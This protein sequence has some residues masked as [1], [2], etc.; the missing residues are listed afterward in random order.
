MNKSNDGTFHGG[1]VR[2]RGEGRGVR[3]AKA[4]ASEIPSIDPT[5]AQ[6]RLS[7][8]EDPETSFQAAK[9]LQARKTKL[10]VLG[11]PK[12]ALDAGSQ[13]YGRCVKH[14]RSYC[15]ARKKEFYV[16]HGY[17]S[18]GVSALLAAASLALSGSRYLYEVAARTSLQPEDRGQLG[19]AQLIKLASSLSDSARQN[20]LSAWELCAREAV[21]RKRNDQNNQALPWLT[22]TAS[23]AVSPSGEVKRGRGRP[24]KVQLL[25]GLPPYTGASNAGDVL[26]TVETSGPTS[27]GQ[28]E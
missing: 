28:A 16:A 7:A 18:S 26:R 10:A 4:K 3:V 25:N 12:E 2:N 8:L 17:V 6:E 24:R 20:E 21:V 19:Q 23:S 13:E 14:A 1:F 15:K 11:I 5:S 9:P 22:Q 27:S